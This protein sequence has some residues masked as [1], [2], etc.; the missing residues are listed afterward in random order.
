MYKDVNDYELLYLIAENDE[1]AYNSIY[2]K[3][4]NM[5]KIQANKIYSKSKYLGI[6]YD[7]VYQ[8]GLYG[9]TL[10]IKNYNENEGSLFYTFANTFIKREMASCIRNHDRCK[11][12]ILSDSISLN[13]D[14]DEEGNVVQDFIESKDNSIKWY[15]EIENINKLLDFKYDLPFLY[16]LIYE[17]RMNNFSNKEIAILLDIKYKT[18]DNA[19]RIIKCKLKKQLNKIEVF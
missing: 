7:D 1:V 10:A 12:N 18:I 4:S 5:V 6:S 13:K 11:H 14:I 9:L 15:D 2:N 8:A 16:S 17:L 3:Y 19:M